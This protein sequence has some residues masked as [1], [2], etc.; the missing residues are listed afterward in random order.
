ML[1]SK[2]FLIKSPTI[3]RN[4]QLFCVNSFS[5]NFLKNGRL[6]FTFPTG[7]AL[8]CN[9]IFK[10][11]VSPVFSPVE[12]GSNKVLSQT[13]K[14]IKKHN[15]KRRVAATKRSYRSSDLTEKTCSKNKFLH[16]NAITLYLLPVHYDIDTIEDTRFLKTH[17]QLL[18][19]SGEDIPV[20]TTSI[21]E[22]M[23]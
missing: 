20:N 22:D 2:E 4:C 11:K 8:Q 5:N 23:L 17:L 1:R 12:W 6:A 9:S 7:F 21:V 10:E 15:L 14:L 16:S 3:V 13:E 18:S 19:R